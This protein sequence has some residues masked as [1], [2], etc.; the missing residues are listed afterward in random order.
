M[1]RS[2]VKYAT[3]MGLQLAVSWNAVNKVLQ[4]EF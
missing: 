2:P 1:L 3:R 4:K